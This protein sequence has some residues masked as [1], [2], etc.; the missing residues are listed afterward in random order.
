METWK[1]IKD[2]PNY[3]VSDLGRFR[4]IGGKT[5]SWDSAPNKYITV[6]INNGNGRKM[7]LVH[8]LII[9]AFIDRPDYPCEVNHK[10]CNKA[11]NRLDNLEYITHKENIK[12]AIRNG[13]MKF[14]KGIESPLYGRNISIEVKA[15]MREAHNKNGNHPNYKLTDSQVL[16]LK[17]RRFNGEALIV[18]AYVF[19]QTTANI[20]AICTGKR[21]SNI[22]HEYTIPAKRQNHKRRAKRTEILVK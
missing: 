19:K 5:L 3:E 6:R 13:R 22:G 17:K 16:D 10:D 18:L 15:K 8:I 1:K 9:E 12:H 21:R 2:Y 4:K 11:N 20:S 7:R 14:K